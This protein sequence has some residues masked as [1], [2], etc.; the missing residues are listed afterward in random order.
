MITLYPTPDVQR[1][2]R[3]RPA[4]RLERPAELSLASL[5]QVRAEARRRIAVGLP[6]RTWRALDLLA[7]GGVLSVAHLG[8]PERTVQYWAKQG[9]VQRL[10][11]DSAHLAGMLAQVGLQQSP[12]V[13][14]L[15]PVGA[16]M[17]RERH[18]AELADPHLA[19][20]LPGV[21]RIILRNEIVLRL[22]ENWGQEG[23]QVDWLAPE[24][25][26]VYEKN[27]NGVV[28]APEV[29]LRCRRGSEQRLFVI[30]YH[31]RV[32]RYQ[33]ESIAGAFNTA[34]LAR[35]KSAWQVETFPSLLVVF[36]D[37]EVGELYQELLQTN[38]W[39]ELCYG[40]RL[41]AVLTG[42]LESWFSFNRNKK[43]PILP[44][45]A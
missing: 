34:R 27:G 25:T 39:T 43:E 30:Q 10:A 15:G 5:A 9:L 11:L 17:L 44:L 1:L 23:W 28:F 29:M 21:L 37:G 31:D 20:P 8:A 41:D 22:A 14:A 40:K 24:K 16:E 32:D 35:W 38:R 26:R 19:A 3:G 4:Q 7:V 42:K 33:V 18:Q 36:S 12:H 2:N 13:Y 6:A 45:S